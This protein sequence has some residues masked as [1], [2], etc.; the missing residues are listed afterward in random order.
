M[1][2]DSDPVQW[3]ARQAVL[4]LPEHTDASNAGQIRGELLSVC[5]SLEPAAGASK[6]AA[7]LSVVARP[8]GRHQQIMGG[9]AV[10]YGR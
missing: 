3:A 10:Q 5:P 7:A 1:R 4:A 8:E 2:E 9:S 6:P